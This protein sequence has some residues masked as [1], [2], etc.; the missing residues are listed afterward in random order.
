MFVTIK[1]GQEQQIDFVSLSLLIF[2]QDS[3]YTKISNN[4]WE[5]KDKEKK[6]RRVKMLFKA[7]VDYGTFLGWV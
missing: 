3:M 5:V 2:S 7:Q 1:S 4:N 6:K